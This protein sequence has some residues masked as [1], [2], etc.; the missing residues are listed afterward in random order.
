MPYITQD[1]RA[2][3]HDTKDQR[4]GTLG[5]ETPGDLNYLITS[6]LILGEPTMEEDIKDR[7]AAFLEERSKL[8]YQAINDVVG[9]LVGAKLELKRRT[10]G[11]APVIDKVLA[12]FYAKVA[13]PYED[14][15]IR[16]NGD[17]YNHE[18]IR[19]TGNGQDNATSATS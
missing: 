5:I 18:D 6:D 14:V 16:E 15:K 17:V 3:Y 10:H 19:S 4:Y 9:A 11:D 2:A 8:N 1:R 12:D 13:A 7:I